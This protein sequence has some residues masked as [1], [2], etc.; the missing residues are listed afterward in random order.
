[1]KKD[2]SKLISKK[3]SFIVLLIASLIWLVPI[4]WAF[5]TSFKTT[6]E[7][8][9]NPIGVFPN[10]FTFENYQNLLSKPD[11]PVLRWM[12]NSF[13]IASIHTLLYLIVASLAAYAFSIL[14]FKGR[15][16]LF[17][18]LL[19]T[20]MIPSVINLVP[21]VTMMIDIA[22]FGTWLPLIIPGL[23]GVFGLFLLRQFF[24]GIPYE[25]IESAKIDG[26]GKF[27]I[28]LKIVV[29]LSKSAFMVAA[30]FAFLGN[31]NDYLWPQIMLTGSNA[32]LWTLPIGL[33]K[34]SGTYNYDYGLTMAA[35]VLSIAPVI[36]I[37]A[38]LQDKIIEGVARTGLK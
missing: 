13:L 18:I 16:T 19:G 2:P 3:A 11:T 31:W 7:I 12:G 30:L 8:T 38:F 5:S 23:G 10:Y 29:P 36:V 22:W 25:L 33:S 24:L 28:F 14:K 34:I 20:T 35:A 17:W 27:G 1:M 15:D 21:L 26:L 4:V 6:Q 9:T 37:Y 32:N